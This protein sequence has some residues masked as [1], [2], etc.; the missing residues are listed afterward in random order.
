MP[1]DEAPE[2]VRTALALIKARA[3]AALGKP[4]DF[5]EI[6]SAAYLEEQKMSVSDK[7]HEYVNANDVIVPSSITA[8]ANRAW[9]PSSRL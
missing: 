1:F 5:N 7:P 4:V 8:I 6:L 3:S 9:G 2:A